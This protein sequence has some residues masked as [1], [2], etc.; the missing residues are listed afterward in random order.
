MLM[1]QTGVGSAN[2]FRGL[3]VGA[4]LEHTRFL[5]L[6]GGQRSSDR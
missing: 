6:R 1:A 3:D 4:T 2:L 5:G